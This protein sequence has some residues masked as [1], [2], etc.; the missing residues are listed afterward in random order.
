MKKRMAFL[1]CFALLDMMAIAGVGTGIVKVG[2]KLWDDTAKA[3]LKSGG[4]DV[5]PTAV[6]STSKALGRAASKYGDDIVFRLSAKTPQLV[7]RTIELVERPV[8]RTC[9]ER[10][11]R[12]ISNL[13]AEEITRVVG[14]MERNPS[15][16]KVIVEHVEKGG[17][18]FVDKLFELNGR[19]ILMG[20]LS[21]AAIV[22]AYRLTAAASAEGNAIDART[23]AIDTM[24]ND[25]GTPLDVKR[26]YLEEAGKAV[27]A[28]SFAWADTIRVIGRALACGFVL[29]VIGCVLI[30]Q[31]RGKRATMEESGKVK[32]DKKDET[33]IADGNGGENGRH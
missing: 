3:V 22:G 15:V 17:V 19:Q 18:H 33:E 5:T 4:K 6:K 14:A 13:P 28:G 23:K 7:E 11:M 1:L 16:A 29:F 12:T 21:T 32:S 9:G 24:M 10:A 2:T 8:L 31:K 27:N 25:P 26:Q 30:L 20:G